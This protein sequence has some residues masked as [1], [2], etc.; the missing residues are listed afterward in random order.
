M[1][2]NRLV[3]PTEGNVAKLNALVDATVQL[4]EVKKAVDKAEAD[5]RAMKE[6]LGM[7]ESAGVEMDGDAGSVADQSDV[8]SVVE[9][10]GRAQ[11]VASVRSNRGRKQQVGFFL[12]FWEC[13]SYVLLAPVSVSIVCRYFCVEGTEACE[14]GIVLAFILFSDLYFPGRTLKG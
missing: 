9:D 8:A 5:I 12:F 1:Y 6:K 2:Y 11:S 14:E 10:F 13:R 7:R 4:L 3:M